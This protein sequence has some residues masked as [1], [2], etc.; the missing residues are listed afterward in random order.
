MQPQERQAAIG[1]AMIYAVRMLGLFMILPVFALYSEELTGVTPLLLGL[2]IGIYGLTQAALQIPFG[3]LSDRL[4]RKPVIIAGLLIFAAGSLLAAMSDHIY[5]V[6]AGRALQGMGAIAAVVMALAA[7]LS[8]DSQRTK[9]MAIIGASI[10]VAF[11]FSMYLGPALYPVINV[12]GL[13]YLTAILA[14][15]AIGVLLFIVPSSTTGNTQQYLQRGAHGFGLAQ[16]L[17]DTQ[18]LRLDISILCLHLILTASFLAIPFI[19]RDS[20]GIQAD[21]HSYVY[22]GIM[23]A[24]L[25]VMVPL[26]MLVERRRWVKPMLF[27]AVLV[28]GLAQAGMALFTTQLAGFLALF[29]LY[30]VVFNLLEANLPSLVSKMAPADNKGAALGVYSSSQFLGAFLGGVFGG[31]VLSAYQVPGVLFFCAAVTGLWFFVLIGI[32]VPIKQKSPAR[33][34]GAQNAQETAKQEQYAVSNQ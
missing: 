23:L 16:V 29:F 3:V 21:Q 33:D 28:M 18:L 10:G 12:S 1:L 31:W 24:A 4:G 26:L 7:D 34:A 20:L 32:K 27:C 22:L 11:V 17:G 5:G 9:V 8:R 6:I 30:F 15:L 14:L 13:F 19:L 25:L 2:A